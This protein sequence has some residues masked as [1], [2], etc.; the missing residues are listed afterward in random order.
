MSDSYDAVV[1]GMGPGGEVVADRL[2]EAGRS[3]AVVERELIGGECAYWA[4][5]PSKTLLRPPEARGGAERAAGVDAPGLDW[6]EAASYRDYIVRHL[7]DSKQA[8]AYEERGATVARGS[9]RIAGRGSVAVDGRELRADHIVVATGSEA[10]VPPIEGLDTVAVW[11]NREA[12]TL[13][14]MPDRALVVGGGPVGTELGQLMAR[15][16]ANVTLVQGGDRLLDREDPQVCHLL[17]AALRDD[18][19][20][21]HIGQHLERVTANGGRAV[22]HL[23]DGTEIETDVVVVAAGRAPRVKDIG[24]ETVG[25]EP[26]RAG[27]KVD[28]R[29]SFGAGLWAVGDVTGEMLFT[30]VAKYQG[31]VVADNILGGE[32]RARYG[33]VPRV[34]FSDPEVGAAGLTEEQARKAGLDVATARVE[35]AQSIARPVTYEKEP[36]GELELIADR[37]R[38]VLVGAWAV[39]PLASEWIHVAATAIR[40]EIPIDALLDGIAQFPTYNEAYL[41][42]LEQLEL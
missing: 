19:L 37:R 23:G 6:A 9:G 11:T 3:V 34:V 18:G 2:I 14:Q 28:D 40:T 10:L 42:A 38:R 21:I 26:D 39:S 1:I 8:A 13:E 4:C 33:G 41:N 29:C 22:A 17:E 36:R 20:D 15:F 35:L 30:H 16:G 31:R 32:R 7:D 12:T 25:V 24:L 5:V 27:L